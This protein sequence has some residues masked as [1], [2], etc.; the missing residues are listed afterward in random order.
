MKNYILVIDEGTTGVRA[1]L[2]DRN[3][4]IKGQAYQTLN[5]VYPGPEQVEVNACEVYDKTVAVI[6]QVVNNCHVSPRDIECA[7]MTSQRAT[8]LFWDK[9]TGKPL[10]NAVT[11]MD[12]RGIYQKAKLA[13]N[14]A[15]NE[16]FPG[17]AC[18][19][20][21]IWMPLILYKIQEDEPEFAKA[22]TGEN[23]I[24]GHIDSYLGWRLTKGAVHA[25]TSS[26]ASATGVYLSHE[27]SWNLP[28]LE[29][30]GVKKEMLPE[31]REESGNFGILD[32]EILGIELPIYSSFADQQA[33]L[34][35]QGCIEANSVKCTMGTGAFIDINLGANF[36]EVPPLMT[37]I[38]WK[39]GGIK[40]YLLEGMS[41]TA[42]ACLEWAKNQFHLFNDFTEME[43]MASKAE[44][45]EG[46]F[47]IP[48]LA[49]IWGDESA[50]GAY[51]GIR[52]N[53]TN[54]HLMR[55]TLEGIAFGTISLIE[56][57]LFSNGNLGDSW[58]EDGQI[59]EIKIS[60]GV[61]KSDT[62]AQAMANVANVRVIRPK[63]VEATALGAAEAAAIYAGWITMDDIEKYIDPDKIYEPDKYQAAQKENYEKWKKVVGRTMKWEV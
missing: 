36:K 56:T 33:A 24:F 15:F 26:A 2:F 63:S 31:I 58:T 30:F 49:G 59:R 42:G 14:E 20:P 28:I 44:T 62:I 23:I 53:I 7:G 32:K 22:M 25:T 19:V 27:D 50:K 54:C 52:P 45:S 35:S 57:A 43:A 51:M 39:I 12:G 40:K 41:Y 60:G 48:A 61:S 1:L 8:W 9:T 17:L 13:S 4:K 10:R 16:K 29:F 46:C 47:F 21:G 11:W 38:S 55:A 34:F 6:R 3:L 18:A 37:G 5:L